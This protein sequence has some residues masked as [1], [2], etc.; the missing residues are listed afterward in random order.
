MFTGIVAALGEITAV[1][2]DGE[3]AR[4]TVDGIDLT[5]A[6]LGDSIAVDGVCLTA[7]AID[8]NAFTADLLPETRRRSTLG[9]AG[10]GRKVNLELAATPT[11][12]LG[13]HLVQG[14]VDGVAT[15]VRRT[16]GDAWD[17]VVFR[18]PD[19]LVRYVVPKGSIALDGVSLTVVSVDDDEVTVSLIPETLRRTTLGAKAAG[20]RVNVE[21]DVIAK[22]VERLLAARVESQS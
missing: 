12:R 8:G 10:A 1:A 16:P 3:G 13:G 5:G 19:D 6:A 7:A 21:V 4:I 2:A 17:D 11:T 18:V 14:H 9:D 20:A 22:Y 15:V